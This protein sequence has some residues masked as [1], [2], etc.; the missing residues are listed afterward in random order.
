M[1]AEVLEGMIRLRYGL[2]AKSK[3]LYLYY[4]LNPVFFDY[5]EAR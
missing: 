3:T 4:L 1:A 2:P 5:K